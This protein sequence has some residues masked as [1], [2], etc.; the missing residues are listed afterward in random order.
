M[1]SIVMHYARR[2]VCITRVPS[3][4]EFVPPHKKP[5]T[6]THTHKNEKER[7]VWNLKLKE[8]STSR[9]TNSMFA[10]KRYVK[11]SRKLYNVTQV[12]ITE[13]IV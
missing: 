10:H 3:E 9:Y 7:E 13:V 11:N 4:L 2:P 1:S 5:N 8:W 12:I 6:H